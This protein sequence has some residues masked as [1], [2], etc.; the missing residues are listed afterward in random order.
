MPNQGGNFITNGISFLK[1]GSKRFTTK[2]N[3][4][5][6]TY[7]NTPIESITICRYPINSMIKRA[8]EIASWNTIQ[9]DKLFHLSMVFNGNILLEKNSVVSMTINPKFPQ[10][11]ETINVMS[12]NITI[13]EFIQNGLNMMGID[14]FFSYSAYDNNC[15][16][17]IMNLLH[18]NGIDN[19]DANHFIKQDTESIFSS[20][21]TLR[22]LTNNITDVDGRAHEIMGGSNIIENLQH[23]CVNNLSKEELA[24]LFD[25]ENGDCHYEFYP[26]TH[27]LIK[28]KIMSK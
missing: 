15:Q 2:V 24:T 21:P 14:K 18:A 26:S 4:I 25:H 11:T 9:Y 7:G 16:V 22:R 12:S 5:L 13:N 17:F 6:K 1:S 3:K 27:K 19:D 10:D 20:N 23:H 28:N 8:L